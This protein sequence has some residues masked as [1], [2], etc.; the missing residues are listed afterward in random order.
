MDKTDAKIL[1]IF[2]YRDFNIASISSVASA[3]SFLFLIVQALP[4]FS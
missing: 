4:K 1:N 2:A 3:K